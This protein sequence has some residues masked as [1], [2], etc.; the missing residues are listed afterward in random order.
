M[1]LKSKFGPARGVQI[2]RRRE[3][4]QMKKIMVKS[5]FTIVKSTSISGIGK[6]VG[7]SVD[8]PKSTYPQ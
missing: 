3:K 5:I 7:I 2:S 6:H 8:K 4:K 1:L